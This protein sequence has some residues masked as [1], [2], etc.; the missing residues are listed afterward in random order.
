MLAPLGEAQ[1][2]RLRAAALNP[3]R[4]RID[5]PVRF[6]HHR[7]ASR[8]GHSRIASDC[9]HHPLAR[10]HPSPPPFQHLLP[11]ALGPVRVL[12]TI[13]SGAT[14]VIRVLAINLP[15]DRLRDPLNPRLQ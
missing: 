9:S 3:E 15:G 1:A 13:N 7:S 12:A 4:W 14:L 5:A 10:V 6:G 2:A 11:N 8:N